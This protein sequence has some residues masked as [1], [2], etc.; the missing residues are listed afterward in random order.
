MGVGEFACAQKKM[1]NIFALF[2]FRFSLLFLL[3]PLLCQF[4]SP[5]CLSHLPCRWSAVVACCEIQPTNHSLQQSEWR[6]GCSEFAPISR[7]LPLLRLRRDRRP[8]IQH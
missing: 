5:V 3:L 1:Q 4:L 2:N 8:T 7:L 6:S